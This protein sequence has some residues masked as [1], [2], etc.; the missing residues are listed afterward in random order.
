MGIFGLFFAYILQIQ[1]SFLYKTSPLLRKLVDEA[2]DFT[3]QGSSLFYSNETITLAESGRRVVRQSLH[4]RSLRKISNMFTEIPFMSEGDHKGVL[5]HL[6]TIEKLTSFLSLPSFFFWFS[7]FS[8]SGTCYETKPWVN[9]LTTRKVNVT[10]S[11][12][13]RHTISRYIT[14]QQYHP[15]SHAL[16]CRDE[17]GQLSTYWVIDLGEEHLLICNY[18]SIR[19]DSCK[20]GPQ[21]WVLEAS[22]DGD[23]WN[24]LREHINDDS[25]TQPA[26][27][28]SWQARGEALY[29]SQYFLNAYLPSSTLLTWW[30]RLVFCFV[31]VFV[32]TLGSA[33]QCIN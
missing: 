16:P 33:F 24:I 7:F 8:S 28:H 31:F 6:G 29:I 22:T 5:Y 4:Q 30:K 1:E 27:Y 23:E 19:S 15:I 17:T 32:P 25:M 11:G 2:L 13:G 21:S 14:S 10:P 3:K 26:R 20:R 9:P 12:K 18:Y